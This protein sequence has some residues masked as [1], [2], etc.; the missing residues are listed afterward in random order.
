[1]NEARIVKKIFEGNLEGRRGR[2]RPRL[3]WIN[4]VEDDLRMLGVKRWRRKALE[5]ERERQER[6]FVI[7]EAKVKLKGPYSYRKKKK[8]YPTNAHKLFLLCLLVP[9]HVSGSRCHLQGLQLVCDSGRRGLLLVWCG[10][11][12][13]IN[14][15]EPTP[16]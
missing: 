1:M 4:D 15:Q 12:Q 8:R 10:Y 9:L 13:T 5:R 11:L 16:T 6:A 7:K 2:G 3:R 14:E